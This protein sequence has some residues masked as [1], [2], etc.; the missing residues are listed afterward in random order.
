MRR[1]LLLFAVALL[2]LIWQTD[3]PSTVTARPEPGPI[4]GERIGGGFVDSKVLGR[5]MPYQVILPVGYSPDTGGPLPVLYLLHGLNGDYT[6]W[7]SR[8]A[9]IRA[10]ALYPFILVSVEGGNSWYTDA[11]GRGPKYESYFIDELIPAVE[12]RFRAGGARERRMIAGLSMGGYG[13]IK[14][15]LKHPEEFS[16]AGSF[17]GAVA[18]ATYTEASAGDLGRWVD[19]VFGPA[20]SATRRSNDLSQLADA[21]PQQSVSQLP[22][23]YISCGTGDSLLASNREFRE[24]LVDDHIPHEYRER[25]GDHNWAFWDPE[26]VNFLAFADRMMKRQPGV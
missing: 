7:P 11:Y 26:I 10:S 2:G 19:K 15:G 1:I 8:D 16:L 17:S 20:D 21:V 6:N 3:M 13:A 9:L 25:P 12:S 18:A 23:I 24:H 22:F 4:R 14:M 5:R